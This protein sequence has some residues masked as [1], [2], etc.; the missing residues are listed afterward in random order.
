MQ[1]EKEII[2]Q[3]HKWNKDLFVELYDLYV[4][5][6]YEFIYFKVWTK[7]QAE[8]LTSETFLKAFK[9]IDSYKQQEWKKFSSWLYTIA[10]NVIIDC[11]RKQKPEQSLDELS[12]KYETPDFVKD[13]DNKQKLTEILK[14][15]DELWTDKK[16]IFIMRIWNNIPYDEIAQ[17]TG[18]SV[19][20]CKQIFS[21]TLKKV[22]DK[23]WVLAVLFLILK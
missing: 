6:I 21:R 7:S 16:D 22:Y 23:F 19:T 12:I 14:F 3:I 2:R 15:L 4:S 11:F 17:I 8:D 13:V 5:K 10:N 9:S 20:N 1:D 18:K